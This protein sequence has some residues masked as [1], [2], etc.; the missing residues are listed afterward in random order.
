MGYHTIREGEQALVF[1]NAG[2]GTLVI[3]P[4]RVRKA[5]YS[6]IVYNIECS[7]CV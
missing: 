3:G 2:Q 6:R 1:N 7:N 5:L 4:R